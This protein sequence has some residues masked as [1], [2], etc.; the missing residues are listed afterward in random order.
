MSKAPNAPMAPVA[1]ATA[2]PPPATS[3][4]QDD[5]RLG[6]EALRGHPL[7][8]V[9]TSS[10]QVLPGGNVPT[11]ASAA[12]A[13]HI[14]PTTVTQWVK[15]SADTTL[16]SGPDDDA[17]A[18]TDVPSGSFFRVN[19]PARGDRMPVY[20][21][22]D[23]L[24]RMPGDGWV[25]AAAVNTVDAPAPGQVF[26]VDADARNPLPVWVQAHRG[27]PLMSGPDDNAVT[28][29]DLPQWTFLKVAGVERNG[30]LLVN[31]AGDYATRKPG[32]G[33]V[34]ESSVGPAGDPGV[35]V[36][37]FKSTPLWSGVDT[38]A[39]KFTDLPQWTKLRIVDGGTPDPQR[40]EVQ[41]FGDGFSRQPGMAWIA[42]ADIG[43]I[44]PPVPLPQLPSAWVA[45]SSQAQHQTFGSGEEFINAVGVAARNSM[46]TS[47]VP[48]SVTVAQA[49]LES[50]WGRSRLT[51]QGNNLFGIKAL[52]G[53][54][55]DGVVSL[56]TW[57]HTG[58]GDVIVQAPFRAYK[59]L[60]Q[61]I[62]DHGRFFTSNHRYADALAVASDARA[63][64][65]AI[66][67]DGYATDPSYASKLIG[68]MDK[69][70]LYRFDS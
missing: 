54:G 70:N 8:D 6:M 18:F 20:Y 35:W 56:A 27:T 37:N 66:Q 19:G 40:I 39:V 29:T 30:R 21:V 15:N 24:L 46:K 12:P 67:D 38:N 36:S 58:G 28:L 16:W 7:G 61:S 69:Y 34:D 33:W 51:Q 64:A 13:E 68:L 60:E 32:I 41:F 4:S 25:D 57:E 3:L 22:G 9:L 44:T 23:G 52:N 47:G 42:V 31:Y 49:I 63:F 10:V 53:P 65:R 1:T 26:A 43:P 5:P 50:D 17:A 2:T 48:A 62:D 59:T 55:P 45:S 14:S 11:D